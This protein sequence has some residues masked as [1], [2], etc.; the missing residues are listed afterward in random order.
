[1]SRLSGPASR[2]PRPGLRRVAALLLAAVVTALAVPAPVLAEAPVAHGWWWRA[3]PGVL[4]PVPAPLQAPPGGLY[5]EGAPDGPSAVSALRF[6][7]PEGS[8]GVALVLKVAQE[9]GGDG[10]I[11][12]ACPAASEWVP[13]QAGPWE[14]RP[15]AQCEGQGV[16]GQR[17]P[18]GATW[19]FSLALTPF[20]GVKDFV[21]LPGRDDTRPEGVNGS[22][23]SVAFQPPDAGTLVIQPADSGGTQPPPFEPP[24]YSP[25]DS[26]GGTMPP[27][28]PG[29]PGAPAEAPAGPDVAL[30]VD[31]SVITPRVTPREPAAPARPVS[32]GKDARALAT[33][34]ALLSVGVAGVLSR[35]RGVVVAGMRVVAEDP[36]TQRVGGIGRFRRPRAEPPPP[37]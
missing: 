12:L 28:T 32:A 24:V 7:V 9:Q 26:Y 4:V 19:T 27:F 36:D 14:A 15:E 22:V 34:I 31:P 37:L 21:L 18:D 2:P 20:T 6:R 23:F 33:L 16:L 25:P 8:A 29:S 5:V 13:A 11:I 30:P 17:A 3:Q 35:D 10:A 1:M